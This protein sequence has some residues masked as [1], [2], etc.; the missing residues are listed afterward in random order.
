MTKTE[1]KQYYPGES[2]HIYSFNVPSFSEIKKIYLLDNNIYMVINYPKEYKLDSSKLINLK[3]QSSPLLTED[4]IYMYFDTQII[5]KTELI[6]SSYGTGNIQFSI[7]TI[8]IPYHFLIE[9][10][11][12]QA[13]L[14]DTKIETIIN[15]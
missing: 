15:D 4:A 3:V 6:N 12:S 14:R 1:I 11:K 8:S 13:E 5:T 2:N 9:E 7:N 10:I